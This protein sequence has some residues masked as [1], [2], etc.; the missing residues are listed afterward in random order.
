MSTFPDQPK[1]VFQDRIEKYDIMTEITTIQTQRHL[2]KYEELRLLHSDFA[3]QN[4]E[5]FNKSARTL[6]TD[7]DMK[8]LAYLLKLRN[9][10]K[11]NVISF[12][13]A[14]GILSVKMAEKYQPEL[15]QKDG[16]S[17]K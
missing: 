8:N 11:T 9:D 2:Y 5:L 17:K 14:S 1:A 10:V 6:M 3:Q 13:K 12:E 16:F 4:P 15:L 7:E